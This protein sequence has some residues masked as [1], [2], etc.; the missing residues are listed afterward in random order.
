MRQKKK[1]GFLADIS[2]RTKQLPRKGLRTCFVS[3]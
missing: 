3:K 2:A 1:F